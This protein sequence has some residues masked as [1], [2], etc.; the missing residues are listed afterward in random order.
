MV[1]SRKNLEVSSLDG[2]TDL[3]YMGN[4]SK[5]ERLNNIGRKL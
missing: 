4:I 2:H 3:P 5:E 1:T